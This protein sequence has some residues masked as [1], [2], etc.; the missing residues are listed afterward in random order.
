VVQAGGRGGLAAG[1][2]R[3]LAPARAPAPRPPAPPQ[4]PQSRP[5]PPLSQPIQRWPSVPSS[6]GRADPPPCP[7]G[8]ADPPP[9][10]PCRAGGVGGA[11]GR[12]AAAL[13]GLGA[14]APPRPL[15]LAS[16]SAAFSPACAGPSPTLP[17]PPPRPTSQP[18][19]LGPCVTPLPLSAQLARSVWPVPILS[20]AHSARPALTPPPAHQLAL[21]AEELC[22]ERTVCELGAERRL[23]VDRWK[24]RPRRRAQRSARPWASSR[25][26]SRQPPHRVSRDER[27][28]LLRPSQAV[29]A[30]TARGAA[31][32]WPGLT[33]APPPPPARAQGA[34]R[35]DVREW[36][37][38]KPGA[39][40][41]ASPPRSRPAPAPHRSMA[42]G[43]G[44]RG[45]APSLSPSPSPVP[46]PSPLTLALALARALALALTLALA[47]AG[48]KGLS[49]ADSQWGALWAQVR[50]PC[51]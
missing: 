39:G 1:R 26:T 17:E 35:Y 31:R 13:R 7:H 2:G 49:L 45:P 22:A 27:R 16:A 48:K 11:E 40:T 6:G 32:E 33:A 25:Q 38:G 10:A 4:P 28:L 9:A 43:G 50:P 14:G 23:A 30:Q 21:P 46:S 34:A 19:W 51:G 44:C 24:A 18:I 8:V 12:G 20:R 37:K 15:A 3:H 41:R 47:L 5:A 36:A 42:E 29:G